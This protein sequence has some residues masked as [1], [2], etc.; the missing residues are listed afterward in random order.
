M[1][2]KAAAFVKKELVFCISLLLA[3]A[4]MAFA[5]P[6]AAYLSYIDWHTILLLFCLMAVA[7][8]G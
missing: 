4:S 1:K 6:S 5:P 3:L 2:E 8:A 7:A